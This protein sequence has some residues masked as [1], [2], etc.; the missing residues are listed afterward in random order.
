ML[1]DTQLTYL[2]MKNG[3]TSEIGFFNAASNNLTCIEVSDPS[4]WASSG[5]PQTDDIMAEYAD[6]CYSSN[7]EYTYVPDDNFEQALIDQGY[8]NALDNYVLTSNISNLNG[9]EVNIL[10]ITDLF[11]GRV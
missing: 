5:M 1:Y 2:N 8:D 4:W 9:L 7:P 10:G 3:L 11:L 6:I